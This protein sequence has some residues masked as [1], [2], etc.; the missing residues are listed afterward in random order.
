MLLIGVLISLF[1]I[2]FKQI[3]LENE[4]HKLYL[5]QIKKAYDEEEHYVVDGCL[6]AFR[7][8]EKIEDFI[9]D[10]LTEI[11]PDFSCRRKIN[12]YFLDYY[13]K[14]INDSLYHDIY[15]SC[16]DLSNVTLVGHSLGG[17]MALIANEII[18]VKKVITYGTPLTCCKESSINMTNV[19]SYVYAKNR[20]NFDPITILPHHGYPIKGIRKT[21]P[22]YGLNY[23]TELFNSSIGI[24]L[25]IE[26]LNNHELSNYY[27][28]LVEL[29]Y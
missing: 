21:T 15:E 28:T 9:I 20:K 4:N 27:S 14:H 11:K 12:R 29:K 8:S 6:V 19:K 24:E 22:N 18:K 25:L 1:I 2:S 26:N 13:F 3:F 16:K 10:I 5:D 23:Y 7:G 17:S